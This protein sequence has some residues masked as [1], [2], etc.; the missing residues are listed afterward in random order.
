MTKTS[1][2]ILYIFVIVAT[3]IF[4]TKAFGNETQSKAE[5]IFLPNENF[6]KSTSIPESKVISKKLADG[7][8]ISDNLGKISIVGHQTKNQ[9][10]K[11]ICAENL[12][13]AIEIAAQNGISKLKYRCMPSK[14]SNVI[15]SSFA[16]RG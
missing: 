3:F 15:L 13:I 12:K 1:Q 7:E 4:C 16:F 14:H 5:G 11:Q 9:S 10:Q 8:N 2:K 6:T